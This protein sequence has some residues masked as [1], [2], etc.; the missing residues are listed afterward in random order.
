MTPQQ[1]RKLENLCAKALAGDRP[2]F[3][4]EIGRLKKIRDAEKKAA[5]MTELETQIQAS[6]EKRRIRKKNRPRPTYNPDLPI[7]A[8]KDEIIEAIRKNRVLIIAG[9]TGSGKTTQ[10]PK[11]CMEAG[12]GIDGKIGCTQPRRIAAMTV[13][14]RIAEELGE[15]LGKS[16]GYKIR[17]QDKGSA[18]AYIKIM[19]DGIL[20]AEAQ[21]D[22]WLREYDTIIVDE[23][24]ERSLNIDF[25][26]GILKTLLH[27][28]RDLKLII[29]SATIDTEKFSK[30]FDNAPIIEVSGRMFPVEV[31]YLQ[32]EGKSRSSE[33]KTDDEEQTHV[34]LAAKAVDKLQQ[35]SPYGGD[36]LVFMP[37][38]QDIR[39][40][41]EM[42]EGRKYTGVTVMP[43]FARLSAGEQSR[44]F[45][46][47][48]GRKIIVSTNVAETSVTIPGIKFVVDTG[49]ARISQYS[50]RSRTTALPV[51]PVSKSSADQRKGRCGRVQH[52]VCIRLYTEEDYENRPR[53]T[54]PE[55]LR[56][57]LA[58][59]I[60]RMIALRLGDIKEF[61]FIDRPADKSIQ[62]GF[63]LLEELG[64]IV[65]AEKKEGEENAAPY[66]LTERGRT[67]ASLPL[68]PRLSRI[69][70]EAGQKGCL[71]ELK[72]IAAALSIQDPRERPS[73]KQKAA[74]Q[75]HAQFKDADSDFMTLLKI[76]NIW[77]ESKNDLKS[78]SK[79]RK[80]CKE[81]FLSFRR[82]QEW[83]DIHYQISLILE[84]QEIR[85]LTPMQENTGKKEEKSAFSPKY[86]AIHQAILSGFL[87][88]IAM[89]KE[90]QFYKGAKDKE[91]MLFPGSGLF[92]NPG[93]W[94]VAAEMVETTRLFARIAAHI[95]PEWIEPVG[96]DQC[97]YAYLKPHWERNRGEVT[98]TEQVSLY[99][100]IIH[101]GRP[102]SYGRINP[103][104]A[105]E[106]FIRS[107]IV[108]GDMRQSF[109]FMEH[110]QRVIEE[111]QD[112]ED[113]MRRR[114]LLVSEEDL[115]RFYADRLEGICD[116][117]SLRHLLKTRKDDFL[118]M[119]KEELLLSLP[120]P[121]EL[122]QFPEQISLGNTV[123]PCEYSFDP[124]KENDGVTLNISSAIAPSIAPESV[125]WVVPGLFREKVTTLI[126]GLPKEFR[127]QL[128]PV[129]QT[130]DVIVQD[131]SREENIPLITA[132]SRF[133]YRKFGI[134]IPASAWDTKSLPDHLK[135]RISL[136][137]PHGEELRAGRDPAI[138]VQGAAVQV[139]LDDFAAA[140]QR[141]ERKGIAEWDFGDLPE[142]LTLK[143]EKGEKW[144]AYP[145]LKTEENDLCLRLFKDRTE[146]IKSH[147][148]GMVK[149]FSLHFA[150]EVRMLKYQ[151]ALP[152]S[153]ALPARY[154]GGSKILEKEML[155][156]ILE[157][158]F[159][160]NIRTPDEFAAPA[161]K[162][163]S[164]IAEKGKQKLQT[165]V[166][167]LD[168][169]H[170]CRT[171]LYDLENANR[172]S[173][174]I[175]QFLAGLRDSLANLVPEHFV[176]LYNEER[177]THLERYIKAIAI[178]AQ[179]AI[180]SFEKDQAKAA[181][182][183]IHTD[184]LNRLLTELSPHV[185]E[186]KRNAVEEFFWL[187]E[188]Y[189]VSVFAQELKTPVKVSAKKL[190]TFYGEI[191]RMV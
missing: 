89:K 12:R 64:A 119:K 190:E 173:A 68:D 182:V 31:R 30:A 127:R 144:T 149:L 157:V 41:C 137:G 188:E 120:N 171:V 35:E 138:L 154:F 163:E 47:M 45:A 140:R 113:R 121:D 167:V 134:D 129:N 65:R 101:P 63:N 148:Q 20:L 153:S 76:W 1:L 174:A 152:G 61:P 94:I 107:A 133:I 185:T 184:R 176:T 168:A 32:P 79:M 37:T 97:K 67:M 117:R 77:N 161:K 62:D 178:R 71:E 70:L 42:I 49:L 106:I 17:F 11:F 118:R 158:L 181:E 58:E 87:S 36:I 116:V 180:V 145:G 56:S 48:P 91:V 189:K 162:A 5:R 177:M 90:K 33:K 43:L 14:A 59:V 4:R 53:F 19:T 104:E 186:E 123:I 40:C 98:A 27:R 102:V 54:L 83:R 103:A 51:S 105:S 50:P 86:A 114:D 135:M 8:R 95:D 25:V 73:E 146:A 132:L 172:N 44:V 28:R 141:W 23:A 122:S 34:E 175:I 159:S 84:E 130:V 85:N 139:N 143:G 170:E 3:R 69:L 55:I 22:G 80:Y 57:N 165:V 88:N 125:D 155:D 7:V 52:G 160:L 66:E 16:V 39:E 100:L 164:V 78:Q 29:T 24:H 10:I 75:A 21:G 18:D 13:S 191:Q 15:D 115:Y 26:L 82:M 46:K 156:S 150:K 166:R 2:V 151:L 108:A 74:D 147:K 128:V 9:E 6:A 99:G 136:R 92:A 124:G 72:V 169:Y 38:E 131:M 112:M 93:A 110:N 109:P 187:L 81:N 179:R 111:I 60:L 96:K 183:K 142:T 126:K